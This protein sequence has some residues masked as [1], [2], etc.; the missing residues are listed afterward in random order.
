MTHTADPAHA[1]LRQAPLGALCERMLR[2]G[3][4]SLNINESLEFDSVLQVVVDSAREL[5]G[6]RFGGLTVIDESGLHEALVTSGMTAEQH[7]LLTEMP[8]GLEFFEHLGRLNEPLGVADLA[9][10]FASQGLREFR[11]SFEFGP[12]LVAP[13]RSSRE[14]VGCIYLTRPATGPEFSDE[15]AAVLAMFASQAALVIA[16]A[17]RYRDEQRAERTLRR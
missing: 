13:V 15:D 17:R 1:G 9:A 14:T 3:E 2:L 16:N 10:Y 6:A 8:G 5:T 12:C 4:A 7:R 11:P